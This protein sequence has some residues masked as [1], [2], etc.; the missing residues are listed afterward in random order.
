M[1]GA[2]AKGF[3]QALLKYAKDNN[4]EHKVS[5]ELDLAPFQWAEQKGNLEIPTYTISHKS[6][7]VAREANMKN[8]INFHPE[9]EVNHSNPLTGHKV[10]SFEDEVVRLIREG[11]IETS[12]KY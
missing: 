10:E 4:L 2:A 6:D 3:L 7:R 9:K 12:V 11:I 5:F 8:A 1:G